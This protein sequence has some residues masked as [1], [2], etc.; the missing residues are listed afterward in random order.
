MEGEWDKI[1]RVFPSA[2][3]TLSDGTVVKLRNVQV[4]FDRPMAWSE[5]GGM[6]VQAGPVSVEV[7]ALVDE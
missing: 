3:M 2:V 7:R 1:S 5:P 4:E 6:P